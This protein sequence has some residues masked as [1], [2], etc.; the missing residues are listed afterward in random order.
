[1]CRMLAQWQSSGCCVTWVQSVSKVSLAAPLTGWLMSIREV[2]DPVFSEGLM[3][4]GFAVDPVEGRVSAPC[5]GLVLQ[6]AST[7]P[8]DNAEN[9]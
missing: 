1:M 9:G 7:K 4:E 2:P 6:V 5:A 3:G 8:F